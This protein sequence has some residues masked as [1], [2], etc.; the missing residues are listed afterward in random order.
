MTTIV[1]APPAAI[2]H[3]TLPF[4]RVLFP[5]VTAGIL[6]DFEEEDEK[7]GY[8]DADDAFWSVVRGALN[9]ACPI[10]G[11]WSCNRVGCVGG[12]TAPQLAPVG[13]SGQC[14]VCGHRYEGWDG[15]VCD[16]CQNV[17]R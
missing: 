1:A 10:C 9:D 13:A 4:P 14:S 17:G 2:T 8:E 6:E 5:A 15:G 3:S 7:R 16:A 12:Q 11:L